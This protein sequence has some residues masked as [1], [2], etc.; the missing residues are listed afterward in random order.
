MTVDVSQEKSITKPESG[1]DSIESDGT[2]V[3]KGFEPDIKSD[4]GGKPFDDK[5]FE[6]D[7]DADEESDPVKYIQKLSGKLGQSLR[8]Y[9]DSSGKP[10]FNLE[11]FVINSVIS[12]TN[13][14]EM[15]EEDRKDIINKIERAKNDDISSM[16]ESTNMDKSFIKEKLVDFAK[17][18]MKELNIKKAPKIR[19][20]NSVLEGS[21]SSFGGY[22]PN[23]NTI[24]ITI[25]GR[26]IMDIMRSLAHEMT[27]HQQNISGRLTNIASDGMDGSP[28]E[29]EANSMAGVIMRKWARMNPSFHNEGIGM[30][31]NDSDTEVAEP[32]VVP[33]VNPETKPSVKPELPVRTT[34]L[35]F[36]R[37]NNVPE[38][39]PKAKI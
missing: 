18:A 24:T 39:K 9:E 13:T 19:M 17:F 35:P 25:S 5:G 33:V 27:H 1:G 3:D 8:S 12:A 30:L 6:P 4:N 2:S 11:K 36:R 31:T 28:I 14:S 23:S 34:D 7:I 26:H 22:E 16:N 10:D 20:N 37:P 21:V 32:E 29:N 38:I 15:P